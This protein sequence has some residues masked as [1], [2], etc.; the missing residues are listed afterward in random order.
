MMVSFDLLLTELN[1]YLSGQ[2]ACCR[3]KKLIRNI[4]IASSV[5]CNYITQID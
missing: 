2:K 5:L 1:L 4:G 3:N